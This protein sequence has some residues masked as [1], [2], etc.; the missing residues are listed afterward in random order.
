MDERKKAAKAV[1]KDD[2]KPEF[3]CITCGINPSIVS[4]K[5]GLPTHHLCKECFSAKIKATKDRKRADGEYGSVGVR[6]TLDFTD[7]GD[8]LKSLGESAKSDMRN[9]NMQALWIIKTALEGQT[10]KVV[11]A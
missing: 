6:I 9:V 3:P 8:L 1:K 11:H 7:H 5:T 10:E 2:K 4:K